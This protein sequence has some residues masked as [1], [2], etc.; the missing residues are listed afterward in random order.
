[1]NGW[2]ANPF[3]ANSAIGREAH[4][5]AEGRG[6]AGGITAI[7]VADARAYF[8]AAGK[9]CF[10]AD[11]YLPAAR[12]AELPGSSNRYIR[13]DADRLAGQSLCSAG[14]DGRMGTE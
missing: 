3:I 1:M 13:V 8:H 6:G 5:T 2:A 4:R 12:G 14:R 9:A 7:I 10:G 11:I